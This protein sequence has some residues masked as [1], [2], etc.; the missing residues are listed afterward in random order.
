MLQQ[1]GHCPLDCQ[2]NKSPDKVQDGVLAI[3]LVVDFVSRWLFLP[4]LFWLLP[5]AGSGFPSRGSLC[6]VSVGLGARSCWRGSSG[7][8]WRQLRDP[9]SHVLCK[10]LRVSCTVASWRQDRL[11]GLDGPV[12]VPVLHTGAGAGAAAGPSSLAPRT[13]SCPPPEALW[14]QEVSVHWQ[15]PKT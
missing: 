4:S 13:G 2:S 11:P 15:S 1:T 3:P 12:P 7:Q 6:A 5:R 14:S 8:E 10:L 9:V